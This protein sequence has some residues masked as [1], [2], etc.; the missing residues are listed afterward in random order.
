[1]RNTKYYQEH[2]TLRIFLGYFRPHRKLFALDMLCA[3]AVA[4]VD[5]AFPLVSR[6]SINNLLPG[7]KYLI[8]FIVMGSLAHPRAYHR[9]ASRAQ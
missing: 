7:G 6:W 3:L 9:K 2:S 5:L 4:A 8:F 1:M